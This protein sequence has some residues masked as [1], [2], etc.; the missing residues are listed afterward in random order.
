M[1]GFIEFGKFK[2]VY[3]FERLCFWIVFIIKVDFGILLFK[4][5]KWEEVY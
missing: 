2:V 5:S 3:F 1:I 4:E